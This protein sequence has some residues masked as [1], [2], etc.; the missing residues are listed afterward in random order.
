MHYENTLLRLIGAVIVRGGIAVQSIGYKKWLPLGKPECLVQNLD[1]WGADEIVV[2]DNGKI[3][4]TGTHELL[5]E[6]EGQYSDLW[7]VQAGSN[8]IK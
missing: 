4:E 5:L 3:I 8:G 6:R 2:L 1:R 7:R